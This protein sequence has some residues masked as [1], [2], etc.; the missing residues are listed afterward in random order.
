M[1]FKPDRSNFGK[2]LNESGIGDAAGAEA[3][4]IAARA[5]ASA[6]RESGEYA[7]G[8]TAGVEL[9]AVKGRARGRRPVGVVT[10]SAPYSAALEFGNSVTQAHHTLLNASRE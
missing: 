4:K 1:E 9:Q 7:A 3:E 10:A 2:I 6:P 5:R 8:I